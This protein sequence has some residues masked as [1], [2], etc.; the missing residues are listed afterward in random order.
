MQIWFEGC[1]LRDQ[2]IKLIFISSLS[3]PEWKWSTYG[4]IILQ[5]CSTQ[6]HKKKS[7]SDGLIG[8]T[9]SLCEISQNKHVYGDECLGAVKRRSTLDAAVARP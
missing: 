5:Y 6:F 9:Y 7:D 4:W 2:E 1:K 8:I 3:Y